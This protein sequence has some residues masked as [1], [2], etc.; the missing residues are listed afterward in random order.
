M[1]FFTGA[2]VLGGS[3]ISGLF[4]KKAAEENRDFQ[5]RLSNTS[6]VREVEDLRAAGLN[7]ILSAGG[8]GASTP[9][10]A[11]AK[12][13]DLGLAASAAS[14]ATNNRELA[15]ANVANT[16]AI[17][18]TNAAQAQYETDALAAYGKSPA[19]RET[20]IGGI[21][22]KHAGVPGA[23][24]AVTGAS[25]SAAGLLRKP[26]VNTVDALYEHR[27]QQHLDRLNKAAKPYYDK[28]QHGPQRRGKNRLAPGYTGS[29]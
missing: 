4:Q 27:T 7:P 29:W 11:V 22:S 16:R 17:G 21:L 8:R 5:E 18:I 6:H 23:V 2:A 26:A 9:T 20:V 1:G 3:I 12:V 28:T 10:G 25:A 24:G 19:I 15:K 14:V 13:P